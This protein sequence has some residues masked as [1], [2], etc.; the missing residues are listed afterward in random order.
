MGGYEG[1]VRD[2]RWC[3]RELDEELGPLHRGTLAVILGHPGAGKTTLVSKLIECNALRGL[4]TVYFSTAETREKYFRFM[5]GLGLKLR[6]LEASGLLKF[7]EIPTIAGEGGGELFV[8]IFTDVV[9]RE[10]PDII[11]IDSVTP[12]LWCLRG[13]EVR[14]SLLH[15]GIYKLVSEFGKVVILVADLPYGTEAVELGGI[16][17][18]A[19]VVLVAKLISERGKPTRRLEVRKF[20]GRNVR[21]S[22][23][24]FVIVEG[25]G[26]KV[27]KPSITWRVAS[28]SIERMTILDSDMLGSIVGP[29]YRGEQV[30]ITYPLGSDVP[31]R[32]AIVMAKRAVRERLKTLFITSSLPANLLYAYMYASLR[33]SERSPFNYFRRYVNIHVQDIYSLSVTEV[34]GRALS[35]AESYRPDVIVVLDVAVQRDVLWQDLETF[36]LMNFAFIVSDRAS[37]IVTFRLLGVGDGSGGGEL[38]AEM[39]DAVMHIEPVGTQGYRVTVVKNPFKAPSPSSIRMFEVELSSVR[40]FEEGAVLKA[41]EE[42]SR[43]QAS[44]RDARP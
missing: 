30:L 27:V 21:L 42:L 22:E 25:V 8:N 15:S 3:V 19:D 9:G 7:V 28:T 39:S 33:P 26:I 41:L 6:D 37:G 11:V 35:L 13:E 16:E 10:N 1:A 14:R 44:G 2:V 32:F 18:V 23:I 40:F 24:P 38:L 29:I 31:L 20:R 43:Q 4:K 5:G 12:I 17:F 36:N 34:V